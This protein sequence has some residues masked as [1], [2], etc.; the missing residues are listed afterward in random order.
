MIRNTLIGLAAAVAVTAAAASSA[1]AGVKVYFGVPH[2]GGYYGAYYGGYYNSYYAPGYFAPCHKVTVGHK[3][4]WN[5]YGWI[6]VPV[7]KK[8][9]GYVY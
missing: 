3:T 8:V 9:C 6:T 5:G 2:F 7:K 1:S 4:V